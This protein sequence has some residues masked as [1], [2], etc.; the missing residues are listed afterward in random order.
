M[1][2]TFFPLGLCFPEENHLMG[3]S[4]KSV[5][6]AWTTY[7]P[8]VI[9][10]EYSKYPTRQGHWQDV[11]T[12]ATPLTSPSPQHYNTHIPATPPS[13]LLFTITPSHRI[14]QL[15]KAPWHGQFDCA[16]FLIGKKH[17]YDCPGQ[18]CA[19]QEYGP[20]PCP[21]VCLSVCTCNS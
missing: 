6:T 8:D 21:S 11:E 5:R 3:A 4:S 10:F 20:H 12:L 17:F 2:K 13:A 16:F 1:W 19:F 7:S 9:L 15:P 14:Q 18:A